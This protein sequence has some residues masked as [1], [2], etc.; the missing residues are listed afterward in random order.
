MASMASTIG[1]ARMPTQGSCL[2]LVMTS[3]AWPSTSTVWPPRRMLDVGLNATRAT[4]S[5]PLEI[6]PSLCHEV[7]F[8]SQGE[9]ERHYFHLAGARAFT[10]S[11]AP[12]GTP[13]SLAPERGEAE[14]APRP[15]RGPLTPRVV[16][17]SGER[18]L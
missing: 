17:G 12:R 1:T 15:P 5:W 13:T 16:E 8:S 11:Q 4:I 7:R 9:L 2:P 6:P 14:A 10:A 18:E 3:V